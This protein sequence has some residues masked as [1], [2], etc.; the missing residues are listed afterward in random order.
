MD[1]LEPVLEIKAALID[2][3][4]NELRESRERFLKECYEYFCFQPDD[5]PE[6]PIYKKRAITKKQIEYIIK[7]LNEKKPTKGERGWYYL[8][9]H[10]VVRKI[11]DIEQLFENEENKK[12][13]SDYGRSFVP[14]D[15]LFD[16]C[17][18]LHNECGC[19]VGC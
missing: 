19:Q 3:S 15:E 4:A 16:V 17:M 9:T 14:I 7:V 2:A 11:E 18:K 5:G 6:K 10:Y 1:N 12:N 8:K 13:K